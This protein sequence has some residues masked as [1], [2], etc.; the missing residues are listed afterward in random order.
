M[1]RPQVLFLCTG[2]SA[3]SQM[4][5]GFL[6]HLAGNRFEVFSAGVNP[7]E[8]NPLAIKVMGEVGVDISGQRSKSVM[9]FIGQ[10]FDYVITVCDNAKQTCPIFPGKYEKIHWNLEDPAQTK[11]TEEERLL[12]FRKVRNQIK[13]NIIEFLNPAVSLK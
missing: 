9:E 2:N 7:T 10:K 13:G 1:S 8:V 11:R 3:R 12:I 5:E 4:A 6:R